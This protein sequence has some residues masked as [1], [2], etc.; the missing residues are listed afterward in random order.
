MQ[1]FILCAFKAIETN[2]NTQQ[3]F[4]RPIVGGCQGN[5]YN[6]H[7]HEPWYTI[8]YTQRNLPR[9]VWDLTLNTESCS[10]LSSLFAMS[11]KNV[12]SCVSNRIPFAAKMKSKKDTNPAV[13]LGESS[14]I[15]STRYPYCSPPSIADCSLPM[16]KFVIGNNRYWFSIFPLLVLK[17][18]LLVRFWRRLFSFVF[19][20]TWRRCLQAGDYFK[21]QFNIQGCL[22]Y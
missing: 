14:W 21:N 22:V 15:P 13:Q 6:T 4:A 12:E 2:G 5:F 18:P 3:S 1:Y 11:S 16:I 7:T 9:V 10:G 20:A 19:F 8:L 17:L